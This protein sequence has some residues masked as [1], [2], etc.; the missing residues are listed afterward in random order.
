MSLLREREHI[1]SLRSLNLFF[2]TQLFTALHSV[3][4][5][6]VLVTATVNLYANVNERYAFV[7]ALLRP[8]ILNESFHVKSRLQKPK[9]Y[10]PAYING[11]E[12]SKLLDCVCVCVC[13]E[14]LDSTETARWERLKLVVQILLGNYRGPE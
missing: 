2:G 6:D 8:Q 7:S 11:I 9:S 1:F 12:K 14:V 5:R 13:D 4:F 3:G 10:L